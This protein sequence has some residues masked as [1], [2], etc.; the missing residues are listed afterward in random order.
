MNMR[1]FLKIPRPPP[2]GRFNTTWDSNEKLSA[3]ND[4]GIYQLKINVFI[5]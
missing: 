4:G 5:S 1:D 3:S 2:R